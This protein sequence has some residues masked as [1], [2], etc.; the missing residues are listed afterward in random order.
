MKRTVYLLMVPLIILFSTLA[1][2]V[3]VDVMR[4]VKI[5]TTD[6]LKKLYDAKTDMLLIN[7]LSPIEFAEERIRDSI[8]LPYMHIKTGK[9]QLPADTNRMLV[10]YC[11]GPS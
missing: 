5:I 11:K 4:K 1:E 10:F 7:A 8:N 6:E 3:D 9:A 2:A